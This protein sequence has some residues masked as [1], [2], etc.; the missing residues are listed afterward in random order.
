MLEVTV[1]GVPIHFIEC[2]GYFAAGKVIDLWKVHVG[3]DARVG[4]GEGVSSHRYPRVHL[5][6]S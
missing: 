6:F 4:F 5:G 2:V 1:R 3:N